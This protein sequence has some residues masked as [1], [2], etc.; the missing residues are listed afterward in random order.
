[1]RSRD[2]LTIEGDEPWDVGLQLTGR[3]DAAVSFAHYNYPPGALQSRERIAAGSIVEGRFT[4]VREVHI[5]LRNAGSTDGA[6]Q[7]VAIEPAE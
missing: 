2:A 6:I 1:M 3:F 4:D 5:D 7:L